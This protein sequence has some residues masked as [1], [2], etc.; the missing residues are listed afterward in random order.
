MLEEL[1]TITDFIKKKGINIVG[2]KE[3]L[4]EWGFIFIRVY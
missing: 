2:L 1:N 4:S 3:L